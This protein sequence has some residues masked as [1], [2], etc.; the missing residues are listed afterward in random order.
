MRTITNFLLVTY[1]ALN[2]V[3]CRAKHNQGDSQVAS[4]KQ[5]E[6][7]PD[8]MCQASLKDAKS[9]L[10]ITIAAL[11]KSTNTPDCAA[12]FAKLP[13]QKEIQLSNRGLSTLSPLCYAEA[14]ESLDITQN[15]VV[16]L[17]PIARLSNLQR[18]Y[19]ASNKI[20]GLPVPNQ[21]SKIFELNVSANQIT[22][23]SAVMSMAALESFDISDNQ[24]QT[25]LALGNVPTLK[26][27]FASNNRIRDLSPLAYT[28]GLEQI[29][30]D[31]NQVFDL[32]PLADLKEL[33]YVKY[34]NFRDNPINR[35]GCPIIGDSPAITTY[36]QNLFV[37]RN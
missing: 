16:D 1:T 19:A 28:A 2:L 33:R 7:T 17:T 9:P 5:P 29:H 24:V 8:E 12:M 31:K 35:S 32:K 14:V 6:L 36:C 21:W 15:A 11:M 37:D 4:L 22:D 3:G 13:S 10:G 18:L 26:V 34:L 23:I 25:I 27:L 30:L 20:T